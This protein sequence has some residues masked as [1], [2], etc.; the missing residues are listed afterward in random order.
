PWWRCSFGPNDDAT[1]AD[2]E[3]GAKQGFERPE[4]NDSAWPNCLNLGLRGLT[5]S[6]QLHMNQQ[7]PPVSYGGYGWFRTTIE[8][9]ASA[10]GEKVVLNLG[11]Y[12]ETDWKAYWV[13]LNGV[14]IGKRSVSERWPESAQFPVSPGSPGYDALRF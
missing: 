8:L 1:P 4:F 9:P 2:A 6:T 11:G 14:E 10:R 7:R 13:Y 3:V 12:D 5:S